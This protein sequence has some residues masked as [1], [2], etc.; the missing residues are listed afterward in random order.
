MKVMKMG[1]K[2][3]HNVGKIIKSLQAQVGGR[4]QIARV[5]NISVGADMRR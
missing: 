5:L 3:Q 1:I 2:E 4:G